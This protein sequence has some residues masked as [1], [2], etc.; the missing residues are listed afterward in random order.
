MAN[1]IGLHHLTS[2]K[3]M[4]NADQIA[5]FRRVVQEGGSLEPLIDE[6]FAE[7]ELMTEILLVG[8]AYL[9]VQE[10]IYEIA[11]MIDAHPSGNE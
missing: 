1:I 3:V 2:Q 6:R 7:G 11:E 10:D 8:G 9:L 5:Y 4:V